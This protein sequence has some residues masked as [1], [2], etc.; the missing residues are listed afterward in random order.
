MALIR[1]ILFNAVFYVSLILY[2]IVGLPFLLLPQRYL[3][4]MV[5]VW[6]RFFVWLTANLAGIKME[7][8]GR[9]HL[10]PGPL[11]IAAKHQSLWETMALL[12][13]FDDPCFILKRELTYLPLFGWYLSRTGQIPVDRRGG[14]KVRNELLKRT[15]EAIL[16]G[17]GRQLIMFPEGTRRP[18]GA[19][20][21]YRAGIAHV[22]EALGVAV[23]PVAMNSGV[24]WPRRSLKLRPGTIVVEF[25]PDIP[26]GLPRETFMQDLET[27]IETAT[28][29]LI[30][31]TQKAA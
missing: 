10:R 25:L 13:F 2:M 8:R 21:A 3:M 28:N 20:P 5:R 15:R 9:E 4:M 18:V 12:Q 26:P 19:P 1:S 27:A 23:T 17:A 31:A 7:V 14:A 22:Y 16:S 24:F 30:A 29:R 6:S 11:L